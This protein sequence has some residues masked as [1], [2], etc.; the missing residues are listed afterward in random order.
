MHNVTAELTGDTS[1]VKFGDY[2]TL[3]CTGT[4]YPVV[5]VNFTYSGIQ[6]PV[7]VEEEV[8]MTSSTPANPSIATRNITI[9]GV[10]LSECEAVVQCVANGTMDGTQHKVASSKIIIID[11]E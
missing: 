6:A 8:I 9:Q 2:I 7:V 11:G 3:T 10:T 1:A 5:S 4:G